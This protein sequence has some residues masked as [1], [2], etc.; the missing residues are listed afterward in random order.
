MES[1]RATIGRY[2]NRVAN[3]ALLF[4]VVRYEPKDFRQ[5][6]PNGHGGWTPNLNGVETVLYKLPK[7]LKSEHVLIVEGEK[8]VETACLL[9]LPDGWAATCNP[10]GAGKWRDSYSDALLGKHVVILPDADGRARHAAQV[11]HSPGKAATVLRLT[12]PDG[13]KDLSLWA[14]DRTPAEM[15]TLLT[16]AVPWASV[17]IVGVGTGDETEDQPTVLSRLHP[18]A[19]CAALGA[20]RFYCTDRGFPSGARGSRRCSRAG[21]SRCGHWLH[22]GQSAPKR[23]ERQQQPC[24]SAVWLILALSNLPP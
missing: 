6:R 23:T 8:D 1:L 17:G 12:L 18:S 24:I 19:R 4:Q 5:R 21:L 14:E 2:A 7:V 16:L 22:T 15:H 11:A 3:G 20:S 13:V 10:M 9:G